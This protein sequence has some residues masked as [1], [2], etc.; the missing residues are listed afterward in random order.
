MREGAEVLECSCRVKS[1]ID[2]NG[3]LALKEEIDLQKVNLQK[4]NLQIENLIRENTLKKRMN[5]AR[6]NE[7]QAT[8]Q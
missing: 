1:D 2:K 4:A 6:L 5:D 8:T 7:I 3:I